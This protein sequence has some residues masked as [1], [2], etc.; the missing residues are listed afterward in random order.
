M[1]RITCIGLFAASLL[2]TSCNSKPTLDRSVVEGYNKCVAAHKE[3]HSK[4]MAAWYKTQESSDI[5][6]RL[7]SKPIDFG[8]DCKNRYGIGDFQ[9]LSDFRIIN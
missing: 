4:K 3:A 1:K 9:D 2:V 6:V 5:A 7:T 8:D